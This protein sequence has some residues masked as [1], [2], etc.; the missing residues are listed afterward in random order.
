MCE[1]VNYIKK[2]KSHDTNNKIRELI[3]EYLKK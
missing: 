3:D 1:C 2:L